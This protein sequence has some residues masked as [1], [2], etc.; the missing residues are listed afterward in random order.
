[1]NNIQENDLVKKY[2]GI[3]RSVAMSYSMVT[4]ENVLFDDLF[5]VG[6]M[7]ILNSIRIGKANRRDIRL[8]VIWSIRDELRRYDFLGKHRRS[9]ANEFE[10][11]IYDLSIK[12]GRKPEDFEIAK[13]I[14]MSLDEYYKYL[15]V[16]RD[17]RQCDDLI[18]VDDVVVE[19]NMFDG[20]LVRE[21]LSRVD[22][23]QR[24]W[25]ILKL[26][27]VDG[28]TLA[29]VGKQIG[30]IESR[31]CQIRKEILSKIMNAIDDDV[32]VA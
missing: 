31:V 13:E 5:S 22:L 18:N 29:E 20:I 4:P 3:A 6:L 10:D 21:A 28:Y 27:Y 32:K 9:K 26:L 11:K 2:M 19:D 1:M 14:G 24:E 30:V 16:Y 25:N 23:S 17:I 7:A 8:K 15:I 12:L